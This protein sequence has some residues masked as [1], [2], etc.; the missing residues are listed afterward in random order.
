MGSARVGSSLKGPSVVLELATTASAPRS[1]A[2]S[3]PRSLAFSAFQSPTTAVTSSQP[4]QL[5]VGFFA[6][7]VPPDPLA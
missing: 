7:W 3:Q 2:A 1:L 6:A 5:E 4:A